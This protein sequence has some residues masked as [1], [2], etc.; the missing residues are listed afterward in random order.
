MIGQFKYENLTAHRMSC[1][2]VSACT[3]RGKYHL[4]QKFLLSKLAK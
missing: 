3:H 4:T 1:S 2:P